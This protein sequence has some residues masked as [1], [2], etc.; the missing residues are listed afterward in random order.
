MNT[1]PAPDTAA[2]K[3]K[4]C[5][6]GSCGTGGC[7]QLN[8]HDWLAYE[9]LAD[10]YPTTDKLEVRFKGGRKEF[11]RNPSGLSLITGDPVLVEM[12]QGS[13]VGYVSMT[14][15]LVELQMRKKKAELPEGGL[16]AVLR[17][18]GTKDLDKLT[19]ARNRELPTLFRTRQIVG[20]QKLPMKLSDVEFQAD[21][22]KATFY[23]SSEQRIDFRELVKQLGA[24]FKVRV[25]MRQISLRQEAG[26]IGGIG[27]CGRELC[28]STW[29][30][31]FKSVGT[32]AARYQNLSLNPAKLSGQC[33]R[34]KCCL[35]YELDTY[36]Q[37]LVDIPRVEKLLQTEKGDAYLQKTDIFRKKMWFNYRGENTWH[38][39]PIARVAYL[40]ELNKQGKKA[41][42]LTEE[43]E[44]ALRAP[45]EAL[46]INSDLR[47]MDERFRSRDRKQKAERRAQSKPQA[48]ENRS[49]KPAAPQTGQSGGEAAGP[50]PPENPRPGRNNRRRGPRKPPQA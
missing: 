35:N 16:R 48:R 9:G 7:N 36:I 11:F 43:E 34:L 14:G 5:S 6:S 26:R 15:P 3:P 31:D 8:S 24:E 40:L 23:Y 20:E 18:A 17:K 50:R 47:S 13:H 39:L 37:E 19:E 2:A 33:G 41:V 22:T 10:L 44:D 45:D 25:E 30:T 49:G 29:L 27:V 4:G 42:A 21:N 28:C 12:A 46:P 32:S 38:E 1:T